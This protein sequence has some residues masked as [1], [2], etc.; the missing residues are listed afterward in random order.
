MKKSIIAAGA[1]SVALAAMPIVGAFA[2]P[3]TQV[4]SQ[5]DTLIVSIA[6]ACSIGYDSDTSGSNSTIE[7]EGV[8]HA[9][10]SGA[11]G[12]GTSSTAG[13]PQHKDTLNVEMLNQTA[14]NN[15]G[16][17]T[18]GIYCNNEDGYQI[19][20]DEVSSGA[21]SSLTASGITANIPLKAAFGDGSSSTSTGWSFKVA[22]ATG[23]TN[24]GSVVNDH[25]NWANASAVPAS[26]I[27]GFG[28]AIVSSASA[29]TKTTTNDGDFYTITYGVGIDSTTPAATYKGA[30]KYT[31][32]AL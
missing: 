11:W 7:V 29:A 21:G 24:R 12:D 14:T 16:T 31:L 20:A 23:A 10:G 32:S 27:P 19:V 25:G 30:I 28:D 2:A 5:T 26:N 3:S 9:D 13:D 8:D 18:L 4:L 22:A 17:T 15:A 1:A 6:S